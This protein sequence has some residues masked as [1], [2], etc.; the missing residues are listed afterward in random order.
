MARPK[1]DNIIKQLETGEDFSLTDSQYKRKTGL[2]I[3]KNPYY[4]LNSSA[5]AGVAEK[6]G[7]KLVIQE[8]TLIFEKGEAK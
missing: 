7:Y 8:R 2:N 5:V 1:L 6:Y 4:L 3:P